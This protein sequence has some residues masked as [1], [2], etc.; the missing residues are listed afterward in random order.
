M[1]TNFRRMTNNL[2]LASLSLAALTHTVAQTPDPRSSPPA[3]RQQIQNAYG[4]LPV[5][6]EKNQ[7]QLDRQVEFVSRGNGYSLFLTRSEAVLSLKDAAL[8]VK[9]LG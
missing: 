6:F 4:Q 3:Q 5:S 1:W 7:G 8:R 9:L 2:G